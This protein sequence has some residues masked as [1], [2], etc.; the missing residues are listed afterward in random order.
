MGAKPVIGLGRANRIFGAASFDE[1]RK[2]LPDP[3]AYLHAIREANRKAH[4]LLGGKHAGERRI[5]DKSG[6]LKKH[7]VLEVEFRVLRIEPD[8][9]S[10]FH[11]FT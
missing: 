9:V 7:G 6:H 5:S 4:I 3:V 2:V 10:F 8:I 1:R 11:P